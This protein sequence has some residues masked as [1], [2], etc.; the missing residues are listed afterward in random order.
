[1]AEVDRPDPPRHHD[2]IGNCCHD[3]MRT[4]VTLDPDVVA[5]LRKS[6]RASG[7][8]FKQVLNEAVREGL[9]GC[10]R[11]TRKAERPFRQITFNMGKPLVS[12]TKASALL[13]ELED[14]ELIAKM[15]RRTARR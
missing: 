2:S 13:D 1:M 10:A 11:R 15:R 3:A 12:L 5:L 6:M 7:R 9:H 8:P 4:T 14:L